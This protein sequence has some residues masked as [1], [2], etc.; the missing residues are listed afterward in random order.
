MRRG[1]PAGVSATLRTTKPGT[2]TGR[3]EYSRSGNGYRATVRISHEST[4]PG[5]AMETTPEIGRRL[6]RALERKLDGELGRGRA[7]EL[8]A[9]LGADS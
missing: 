5:A 8:E 3:D 2:G 6:E 1:K 4:N 9:A 7:A